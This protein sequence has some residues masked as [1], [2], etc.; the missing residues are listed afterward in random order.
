GQFD[1]VYSWGVLHHTGDMWNAIRASARLTASR[2]YF[3]FAVYNRAGRR[4]AWWRHVKRLYNRSPKTVR[5]VLELAYM[6]AHLGWTLLHG[7][8]PLKMVIDYPAENRGMR[9]QT[10]AAD[11]LGGYPYE[12]ATAKEM[13]AFM[14]SEFPLFELARITPTSSVSLNSFVFRRR[15]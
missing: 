14:D 12:Y 10:D 13:I 11:W 5:D 2:G 8:N 6:G 1:V 15:D 7:R 9:Y 4:N 3:Y